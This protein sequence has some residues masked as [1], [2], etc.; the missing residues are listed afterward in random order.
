MRQPPI[1][2]PHRRGA[3]PALWLPCFSPC[4]WRCRARPRSVLRS[5]PRR[6][7]APALP[8]HAR[9][10][11]PGLA[12]PR[13]AMPAPP[14]HRLPPALRDIR[15]RLLAPATP[16][17][18]IS[19]GIDDAAPHIRGRVTATDP[20]PCRERPG[21]PLLGQILSPA[22]IPRQQ[23]SQPDH[24]RLRPQHEAGELLEL[25]LPR[26]RTTSPPFPAPQ[27]QTQTAHRKVRAHSHGVQYVVCTSNGM[28]QARAFSVPFTI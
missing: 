26:H 18:P 27:L 6:T 5:S 20:P 1:A 21:E 25:G 9:S 19:V 11:W 3:W 22:T 28:P 13:P 14:P 12:A 7:A 2:G 23:L 8:V 17:P 4:R 24:P 15:M 16:P 10:A